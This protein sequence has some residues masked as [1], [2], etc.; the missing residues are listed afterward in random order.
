MCNI[1][2]SSHYR[3]TQ[4][5]KY[6]IWDVAAE[7]VILFIIVSFFKFN[8]NNELFTIRGINNRLIPDDSLLVQPQAIHNIYVYVERTC[9]FLSVKNMSVNMLLLKMFW[10]LMSEKLNTLKL[11]N[12]ETWKLWVKH[13]FI[14]LSLLGKSCLHYSWL[15]SLCSFVLNTDRRSL[16][17]WQCIT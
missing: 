4:V 1:L 17:P 13:F 2:S 10:K 8:N 7:G 15:E 14:S 5:I 6:N 3:E 11:W 9:A 16:E 12:L